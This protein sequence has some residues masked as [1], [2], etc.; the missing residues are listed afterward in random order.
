[1]KMRR[2]KRRRKRRR[3]RR[4][5]PHDDEAPLVTLKRSNSTKILTDRQTD[6]QI[7]WHL[8]SIM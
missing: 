1:M 3:R 6:G 5:Q 7:T 2:R 4:S 8:R